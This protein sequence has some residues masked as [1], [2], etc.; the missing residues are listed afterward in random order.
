[1]DGRFRK[2]FIVMALAV[3]ISLPTATNN[4]AW[5]S[6]PYT[7]TVPSTTQLTGFIVGSPGV[8]QLSGYSI[9][10][11]DGANFLVG[12]A[13][14]NAPE[15]DY[16]SLTTGGG[17]TASYGFTSG[18]DT[19]KSFTQIT[20]T[21]QEAAINDNLMNGFEYHSIKGEWN[22]SIR[23]SLTVTE[24]IPGVAYYPHDNHYYRVGH[25]YQD[26]ND[27]A[28]TNS[29]FCS[30]AGT[31][32]T[33]YETNYD[34]IED[35][36]RIAK[37][38][39]NCTW[40]NAN[41]LARSATLKDR[42]GYLANITNVAEN[43]FLKAKL[44]GALNVWMGGTDGAV[45]GTTSADA[46]N[47][48][49]F[50]Y[51][52]ATTVPDSF[53][54][55]TEGLWRYYDGPEKG[56]VFWRQLGGVGSDWLTWRS[57]HE[58]NSYVPSAT[59]N[60]T[61]AGDQDVLIYSNWSNPAE[62]NNLSST[63]LGEDNIV[64]NWGSTLGYWNDLHESEPTIGY[65]GYIVEYGDS[66]PFSDSDKK[67]ST[68]V[69]GSK[70]VGSVLN[71][72][73]EN[74]GQ[75]YA[76]LKGSINISDSGTSASFCYGNTLDL[77]TCISVAAS[78]PSTIRANSYNIVTKDLT[79]LTS[80]S[81]YYYYVVSTNNGVD[82]KSSTRSF[83]TTDS[84]YS[85][86]DLLTGK[87]LLKFTE[88]T[89]CT[90]TVPANV[91]QVEIVA[92]AGGGG[93][94]SVCVGGGGGAGGYFHSG[95]NFS[96]VGTFVANVGSGG[97]G[98]AG[99]AGCTHN[100]G[101][102]GGDTVIKTGGG[103]FTK[104]IKGGGGGGF[105]GPAS[106][107]D[108]GS[109]GGGSGVSA[110]G[111][112]RLIAGEGNAG[113]N[114]ESGS[115]NPGG[116]GGGASSVG[117]NA[118][119]TVGGAGGSGYTL[120]IS[121]KSEFFAGGG[122]G[123]SDDVGGEG[124]QFCGG[125]GASRND[126]HGGVE[127]AATAATGYGCG[128]GGGDGN[129]PA[130][131]GSNGVVYLFYSL[132][133]Y[134]ITYVASG[135]TG[136][137]PTES[138]T[139]SGNE[140][141]VQSGS[142]LT[143]NGCL[144]D[145]WIYNGTKLQTGDAITVNEDV[146]LTASWLQSGCTNSGGGGGG[147]APAPVPQILPGFTWNPKNIY[148]NQSI[149]EEQLGAEFSVPGTVTYSIPKGFKPKNGK[150]TIVVTFKPQDT[151]QYLEV[152]ITREIEVLKVDSLAVEG[153]VTGEATTQKQVALPELKTLGKVYFN[154][155]EYFLDAKDRKYLKAVANKAKKTGSKSVLIL[156]H[157]DVKKGVDNTWLS[158]SRANAVAKF[159]KQ[160]DIKAK[161]TEAWFGPRKPAKTGLDKV[162]LALNRRV[163]IYLLN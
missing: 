52:S 125:K 25:F 158:K 120:T 57:T 72:G 33:N 74:I 16:L 161:I 95:N 117:G 26:D 92:V 76:T 104:T 13:I 150:L 151:S 147:I 49:G 140:I 50:D 126:S 109:G 54:G 114:G 64:F 87:R 8:Y 68:L 105:I 146:S 103:A 129:Q 31:S 48:P 67:F 153:I 83:R 80:N 121:G 63:S 159:L 65:Y 6:I 148:E 10:G 89:D 133:N 20:F 119:A 12:I 98:G 70:P 17:V 143:K 77:A 29:V 4:S 47:I 145:S 22:D 97:A 118:T 131:A 2:N 128:G 96:V 81:T 138:S 46:N 82:T 44:Q 24:E 152:Q 15:G 53:T 141:Y 11:P 115:G 116:G 142:G 155:D 5:A 156:G 19:M 28:T 91:T 136:V 59:S 86:N 21:G 106:G 62:P 43:N 107:A 99:T 123:A 144:F 14:E 100:I 132:N 40:A 61:S 66:T 34:P 38:S 58:N 32:A 94:G 78:S 93:G 45:D 88:N 108:G 127:E 36:R 69:I 41:S 27:A 134:S 113:G 130:T 55:G 23:I 160:F 135:A 71:L 90:W 101:A 56:Q 112:A 110:A 35:I 30:D 122:G 18:A 139:L 102:N 79:G 162:S 39:S 124:G 51:F 37:G 111:G 154:T 73:A 149:T 137:V 85:Y 157:T 84:C 7:A 1:M 163:E 75:T 9:D 3:G 60:I 42:P